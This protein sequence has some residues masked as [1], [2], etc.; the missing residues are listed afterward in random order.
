MLYDQYGNKI[1]TAKF[2]IRDDQ[3]FVLDLLMDKR[4]LL[5]NGTGFNWDKPDHFRVVFL[6]R[7]DDL[8]MALGRLKDFL[9]TYR[10]E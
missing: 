7:A 10:Q 6:P 1:D 5:V 2:N 3:K 8:E 4:I 9:A